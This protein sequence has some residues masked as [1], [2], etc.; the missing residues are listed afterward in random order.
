MKLAGVAA[1]VDLDGLD[2]SLGVSRASERGQRQQRSTSA[3]DLTA[4]QHHDSP[5]DFN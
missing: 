4:V 3:N 5:I 2:W 1:Q